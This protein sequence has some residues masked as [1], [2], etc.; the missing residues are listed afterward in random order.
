MLAVSRAI[1]NRRRC[2]WDIIG[3]EDTTNTPTDGIQSDLQ[4]IMR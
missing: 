1:S 2:V 4:K 3:L